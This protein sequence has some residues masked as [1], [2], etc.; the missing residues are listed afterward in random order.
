MGRARLQ[1]RRDAPAYLIREAAHYLGLPPSTVRLW[2]IGQWRQV[3][4]IDP[5]SVN[6]VAL[7]FWNLVEIYV[8]A[9]IRR[10]HHLSMPKVR[11]SLAY[12][13]D[14]LRSQR[15]L[16]EE[17]FK[18]DGVSLFVERFAKLINVTAEGQVALREVLEASLQRIERDPNGL[19]LRLYPWLRDP[20]E[21]R[22]VLIDPQRSF[23]RPLIAEVGVP[24]AVLVERFRA[25][26]TIR[27]LS[28]DYAIAETLVE[29]AIR[30]ESRASEAWAA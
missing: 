2:S 12:V 10:R 29:S 28:Q 1:D 17:Q 3:R 23:G 14:K 21:P 6:P 4:L 30:W 22:H 25:G 26:D 11:R 20:S 7:S 19:A 15:P 16:I 24:T 27:L 5:A 18:T 8:L 9:A 13:K